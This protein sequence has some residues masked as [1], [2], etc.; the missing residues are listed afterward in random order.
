MPRKLFKEHP[1]I[2]NDWTIACIIVLLLLDV[3]VCEA[4]VSL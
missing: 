4:A 2:L 1:K 3:P